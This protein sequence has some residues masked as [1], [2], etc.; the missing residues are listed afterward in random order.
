M[1]WGWLFVL[2]FLGAV[3]TVLSSSATPLARIWTGPVAVGVWKGLPGGSK[4]VATPTGADSADASPRW[5]GYYRKGELWVVRVAIGERTL[6]LSPG[7]SQDGWVLGQIQ[8]QADRP[9]EITLT[10]KK[11]WTLKL[12]R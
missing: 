12:Q 8:I 4:P 7:Q 11:T 3:G 1:K 9:V 10:N 6:S 5:V 2:A